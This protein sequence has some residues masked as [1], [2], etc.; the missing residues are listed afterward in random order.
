MKKNYYSF[1]NRRKGNH[2]AT[3][4]QKLRIKKDSAKRLFRLKL[5]KN[6]I[7]CAYL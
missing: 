5:L 3:T 7:Q 6:V 4:Y 1:L 2:I